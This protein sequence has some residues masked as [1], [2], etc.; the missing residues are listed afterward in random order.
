MV[1]LG[2]FAMPLHP[3]ERV[4]REVME[5]NREAVI[6]ADQLGFLQNAVGGVSGPF[7]AYLALRGVKTLDVRMERH[8]TNAATNSSRSCTVASIM[9]RLAS[10]LRR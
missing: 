2:Y 7:D 1:H 5:E 8:C 6:L 10:K 3:K 4:Y 9:L